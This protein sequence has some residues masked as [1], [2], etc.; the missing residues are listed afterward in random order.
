MA[1]RE[2]DCLWT[3]Q[4]P[5]LFPSPLGPPLLSVWGTFQRSDRPYLIRVCDQHRKNRENYRSHMMFGHQGELRV[6]LFLSL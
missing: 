5:D 1:V 2:D 6:C 4:L 3:V